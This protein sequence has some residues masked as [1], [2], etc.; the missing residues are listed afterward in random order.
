[1]FEMF[2]LPWQLFSCAKLLVGP[3][4]TI[5]DKEQGSTQLLQTSQ[6][7]LANTL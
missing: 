4:P 6:P 7:Q 5:K 3:K 2:N 1:M